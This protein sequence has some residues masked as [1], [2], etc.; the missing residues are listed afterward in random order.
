MSD[1]SSWSDSVDAEK[2]LWEVF[3]KS[4]VFGAPKFNRRLM[5]LAAIG[6]L[7]YCVCNVT[8]GVDS[9]KI[10]IS[11]ERLSESLINISTAI[12]GFLVA[13]FSIFISMAKKENLKTLAMVR[14]KDTQLSHFK[15]IM[16]NF[17]NV[18][19]IYLVA[20]SISLAIFV[21]VPLGKI[22]AFPFQLDDSVV[23]LLNS[24]VLCFQVLLAIYSI[25]RLKS[26]IWNMYQALIIEIML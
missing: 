25:V 2:S 8:L 20:L 10:L 14:Y 21:V 12:L 6:C 19:S 17:L 4:Q 18:F 11:I 15:H 24:F 13:G 26:F 16:F 9:N 22:P 5:F 23:I 3:N 7:I 1:Q